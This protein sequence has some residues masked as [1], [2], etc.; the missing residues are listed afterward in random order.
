[1][2]SQRHTILGACEYSLQ[3]IADLK[4]GLIEHGASHQETVWAIGGII[5]TLTSNLLQICDQVFN[6]A[7][8]SGEP[9]A[10]Q[11]L[12]EIKERFNAFIER[13]VD[14]D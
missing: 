14:N 5:V 11:D 7:V 1:M 6:E 3:A 9:N 2:K 13:M 4:K 10:R 12:T 8:Q